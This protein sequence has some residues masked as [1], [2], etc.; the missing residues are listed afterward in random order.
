MKLFN[1]LLSGKV[2]IIGDKSISHRAILFSALAEGTSNI[3]NLL[4]SEDTKATLKIIEQLGVDIKLNDK[5]L[6]VGKGLDGLKKPKKDLNARNSGTTARLLIGLLS[7][8]NFSSTLTGNPQL[9]KRPMNRITDLLIENGASINIK[10][11]F[12]PIKFN[13]SEYSFH[14]QNTL[15]PSA[16]VKSALIIASLY[17][18]EPTLI[19]ETVATRDHTERMLI[20]MGANI[21]RLG[22]TI[23]VSPTSKLQPLNISIPGDISSGAFLIA[24]GL[25]NGKEIILENMLINERRLG[26]VKILKRMG[27]NIEITNINEENNEVIGDIKVKKSN[28][29][30]TTV[31]KDEIADFIDEIPIFTFLASQATGTTKLIGAEELRVKESDRLDVMK[32]FILELGGEIKVFDDGFEI[33]GIQKLKNGFIKTFEDHR[34]AMTAI[35][36]NVALRKK[37][38]PD[39]KECIKDSYPSFF[40][41]LKKVGAEINE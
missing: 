6:I 9:N 37:I 23:T 18:K 31:N 5:V 7:K 14:F 15:V 21:L 39:N 35:I 33:K 30:G 25:L 34:I 16:Q 19:E 29:T 12:L 4:I 32:D 11:S 8:Q 40:E 28:L 41:D 13:S 36:A 3:Q 20:A 38:V 1:R 22:N 26:F 24:L 2:A 27:A 10:N 17:H